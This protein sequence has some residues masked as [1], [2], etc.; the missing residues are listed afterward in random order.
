MIVFRQKEYSV[1]GAGIG[2]I[3]SGL[4]AAAGGVVK[5]AAT[6]GSGAVRAGVPLLAGIGQVGASGLA[7]GGLGLMKAAYWGAA[8][9]LI[10]GGLGAYAL[11]KILKKRRER[12]M[13]ERGYSVVKKMAEEGER[14]FSRVSRLN[15]EEL[16]RLRKIASQKALNPKLA[17]KGIR[18]KRRDFSEVSDQLEIPMPVPKA[19]REVVPK[20]IV[21]KAK[22]SGVVQK[23]AEGNWRVINMHGPNGQAIYWK[24][25]YGSREKAE[26]A[27][28]SY[29]SGAWS[30]RK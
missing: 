1:L 22:K 27:L 7:A 24:P 9:P 4:G 10:L 20:K 5:G 15:K 23:D 3:A 29:Q 21:K 25:K 6:L 11:Y 17:E 2:N 28:K 19:P 26:N 18:L 14:Y 13:A 16:L 30:K 12:K 8:H